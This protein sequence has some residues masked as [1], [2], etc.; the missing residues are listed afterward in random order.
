[1]D[2]F[3]YSDESGVLDKV[4]NNYFV[5]GGLVLLSSKEKDIACRKY[6]HAEKTIRTSEGILS[7]NEVKATTVSNKS[8]G[9]LF[10]SL[11][12]YEKFGIIINQQKIYDSIF[13]AKKTK[14][15]YLDWAYK[16]AV[17]KKLEELIHEEKIIPKDV[18]NIYFFVDEHTTATDGKYELKE[19][20]EQEFK[21]GIH[22]YEKMTFYPPVF[23]N[24]KSVNLYFCDSNTIT[25]V[26][27]AD[28]IANRLYHAANIN[29]LESVRRPNFL[30]SNHP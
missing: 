7:K 13:S 17:R 12:E 15:R 5:F 19:S 10:R 28:I 18:E 29:S 4:H 30:I 9:K 16:F 22:N 24:L 8:K 20:L 2:I 14:Q 27:A 26:R 11:N 23:P 21:Y 25:L 3:I 6:L 1:M